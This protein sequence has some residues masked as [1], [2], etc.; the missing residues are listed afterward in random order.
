MCIQGGGRKILRVLAH[1]GIEANLDKCVT[2]IGMRSPAIVK[3]VQQL[4][5]E[6]PPCP[7]SCQQEEIRDILISSV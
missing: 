6:W 2:I 3:E 4:T 5:G 1:R 7:D